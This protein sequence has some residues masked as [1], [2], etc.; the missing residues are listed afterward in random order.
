MDTLKR[1]S[2]F[3]LLFIALL[4]IAQI[5]VAQDAPKAPPVPTDIPTENVGPIYKFVGT[6]DIDG[7]GNVIKHPTRNVT[8]GWYSP[9]VTSN[10]RGLFESGKFRGEAN[11][12]FVGTNVWAYASSTLTKA[13]VQSKP[14]C[15]RIKLFHTP[16]GSLGQPQPTCH[17]RT[18][19][20]HWVTSPSH[21]IWSG[22]HTIDFTSPHEEI[23]V[24]TSSHQF[25]KNDGTPIAG[26]SQSEVFYECIT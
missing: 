16:Q 7:Q 20:W 19:A 8:R 4:S 22:C 12:W 14:V 18:Q 10:S 3:V 25:R 23:T 24:N 26:D 21:A 11:L 15:A 6:V 2:K 5:S 17:D 13:S 9:L 1:M